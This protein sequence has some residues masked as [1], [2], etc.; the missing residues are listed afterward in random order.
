MILLRSMRVPADLLNRLIARLIAVYRRLKRTQSHP[1]YRPEKHYM[2]GPGPKTKYGATAS[3]DP[4][5]RA[6]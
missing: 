4:T 2:R 5:P 1:A 3:G 6:T